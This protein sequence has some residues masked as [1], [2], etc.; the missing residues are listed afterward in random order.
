LGKV[1]EAHESHDGITFVTVIEE[2]WR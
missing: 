2:A 1:E